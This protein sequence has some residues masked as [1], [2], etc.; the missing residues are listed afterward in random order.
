MQCQNNVFNVAMFSTS[1]QCFQRRD[2]VLIELKMA[3]LFAKIIHSQRADIRNQIQFILWVQ[4]V[5]TLI[6]MYFMISK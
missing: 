2:M 3:L 6:E 4:L 1:K 5:P